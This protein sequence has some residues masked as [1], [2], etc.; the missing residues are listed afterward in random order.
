MKS[1]EAEKRHFI[2]AKSIIS[3]KT[4]QSERATVENDLTPS[5]AEFANQLDFIKW[6]ENFKFELRR[7]PIVVAQCPLDQVPVAGPQSS[8]TLWITR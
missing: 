8:A 5:G 2:Q 3:T 1:A 4:Y 7:F 6:V